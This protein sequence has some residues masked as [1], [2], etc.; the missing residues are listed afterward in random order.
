MWPTCMI[1]YK[2]T[3][4]INGEKSHFNKWYWN[5]YKSYAKTKQPR[6]KPYTFQKSELT[7]YQRSKCDRPNYK[8][9]RRKQ[10][11]TLHDLCNEVLETTPRT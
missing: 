9:S 11:E 2:D 7:V 5:N 10:E 6:Y 3:G 1:F 8:I 4:Q